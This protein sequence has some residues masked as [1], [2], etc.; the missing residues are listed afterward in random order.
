[1]QSSVRHRYSL[2]PDKPDI[3]AFKAGFFVL[4]FLFVALFNYGM[5]FLL[6]VIDTACDW[7]ARAEGESVRPILREFLS[8]TSLLTCSLL[9]AISLD[10]ALHGDETDVMQIILRAV[11][12]VVAKLLVFRA[13]IGELAVPTALVSAQK[14][15]RLFQTV[16]IFL[17]PIILLVFAVLPW[18][19][20]IP[21][22]V[23]WSAVLDQLIPWHL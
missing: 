21:T 13:L 9:L 23:F 15:R 4:S 12:I 19:L 20:V 6:V 7:Y 18:L 5:I 17:L 10:P 2:A 8:R 3:P 11:I 14:W 22:N 1:M 16:L